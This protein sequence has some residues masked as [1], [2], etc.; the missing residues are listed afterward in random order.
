[1]VV[2]KY[3]IEFAAGVLVIPRGKIE[4]DGDQMRA[5][6]PRSDYLSNSDLGF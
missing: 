6:C 5:Y 4:S 3:K 2:F 1:M